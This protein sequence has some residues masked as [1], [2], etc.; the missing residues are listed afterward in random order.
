[1]C[2]IVGYTG[3]KQAQEIVLESLKKLEYRGYD[4]SGIATREDKLVICKKEGPIVNMEAVLPKSDSTLAIAHTRWATHGVP[5]DAN[6]HPH[7]DSENTIAVVHNGTIDNYLNIKE[8]LEKE[9]Y[10]F[11][12][13]SD[14]EVLP[15]LI[16]K[17]YTGDLV[18]ALHKSLEEIEGIFTIAVI[19]EDHPDEIVAVRNETPLV[20]GVGNS[21]N[22]LASDIYAILKY[23]QQIIYPSD[24]QIIKVTSKSIEVFDDKLNAIDYEIEKVEKY[25][26]V[27]E[28]GGFEHFMLKEIFEQPKALQD[29]LTELLTDSP[30]EK[31]GLNW[32]IGS[33]SV[34]ACGTSYH[35]GLVGKYVIE[36]LTAIPVSVS[37]SSEFRYAAPV[38]GVGGLLSSRPLVV[39]ISQSGETA[40]TL[41][42]ARAARQQGCHTIAI[43]NVPGSRIT[44]EVDGVI[45]TKSGQEIGVAATKTFLTQMQAL[46]ALGVHLGFNSGSIDYPQLKLW[47]SEIRKIPSK[48]TQ[49]LN[50]SES[51][52][53]LASQFVNS[54]S[55]FFVGRNINYPLALEGALKLKEISYIHAEGYPA[56]ELKHGPLALLSEETPVVAIA[57]QDHTY[58]KLISNIEE[59]SARKTPVITV[60]QKGDELAKKVSDFCFEIPEID[61]VLSPFPIAVFMQ[62]LS[63][64][65]AHELGTEIDKPRNLAKSVTVE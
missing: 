50:N 11:K 42:A 52:K 17:Y 32:K 33:V 28:K 14:S 48:I 54:K 6:A 38:Q 7:S 61:P 16:S 19:H 29:S 5:S 15:V 3:N 31:L 26:E 39:L 20:I 44:R 59:M 23:T 65:V 22:Y 34:V 43:C 25:T 13:N 21:E 9:G 62:L 24:N 49:V 58:S 60:A 63:Y 41:A 36:Q 1:M 10:K 45:L 56:G 46:Y 57:V 35:A 18:Q 27:S 64:Y 40:D 8:S 55:V 47:E 51:I 12:S 2:G 53:E 30:L 37:Y 4:S